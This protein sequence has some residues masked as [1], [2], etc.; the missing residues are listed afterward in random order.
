MKDS[1]V[2]AYG[3]RIRDCKYGYDLHVEL[4]VN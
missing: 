1:Y 3:I 4:C 2:I